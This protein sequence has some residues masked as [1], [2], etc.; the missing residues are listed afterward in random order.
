MSWF[1]TRYQHAL[2]QRQ[3]L[4]ALRQSVARRGQT[5][6]A[7]CGDGGWL[8]R[9]FGHSFE[10]VNVVEIRGP[11]KSEW[12]L[13]S[14]FEELQELTV[15]SPAEQPDATSVDG[16]V[17]QGL[18]HLTS[19]Q[20]FG[21]RLHNVQFLRSLRKLRY[22]LLSGTGGGDEVLD[23][24][25]NCQDLEGLTLSGVKVTD[26]KLCKLSALC[27]LCDLDLDG[28]SITD[29]GVR[30]L[31][32]L[33]HLETLVLANNPDITDAGL[34]ELERSSAIENV[35]VEG[36]AVTPV[37]LEG[38]RKKLPN[39]HDNLGYGRGCGIGTIGS[40]R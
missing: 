11:T 13:M 2:R 18:T 25:G 22:L 3:A 31:R 7:T 32:G 30:H 27:K 37:G 38:L 26:G 21:E 19:L 5:L 8:A 36:T 14:V 12:A 39:W 40:G 16:E 4:E 23:E 15:S 20:V 29:A 9:L 28:S 33:A 24:I 35:D 1:A 17:I 34:K 10:L 6:V